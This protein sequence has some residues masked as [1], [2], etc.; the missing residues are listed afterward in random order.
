[1]TKFTILISGLIF[2]FSNTARCKSVHLIVPLCDN[3]EQ[4]IV[5]VNKA[6]GDGKNPDSN[7]YW[8]ALYG[9]RTYFNKSK[10]WQLIKRYKPDS[11]TIAERCVYKHNTT[12]TYLV[13]DAYWGKDIFKANANLF[14]FAYGLKKANLMINQTPI[15]INGNSDL[16]IYAG[17]NGLMDFELKLKTQKQSK[18]PVPV[19]VLA[20]KSKQ[21][22]APIF[23]KLNIPTL[24][25]TQSFMAPE[26]YTIEAALAHWA[27]G[28][29][30]G[31]LNVA[32]KA[33]SKY[34]K[35]SLKA[36]KTVF[37]EPNHF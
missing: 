7:L 13:A 3:K 36:A 17:H 11:K 15:G 19:I 12:N 22:Y 29:K 6:L 14:N 35:C 27:N 26:A 8:G 16:I 28:G 21:Y 1:M 18:S 32:S 5:P 10:V 33:Y 25:M 23:S 34:Q 20:C 24:L 9:V 30:S 37:W 4:G 31:F 2:L